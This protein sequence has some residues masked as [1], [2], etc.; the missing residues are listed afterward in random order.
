MYAGLVL[1][2]ADSSVAQPS[3]LMLKSPSLSLPTEQAIRLAQQAIP[4]II[5]DKHFSQDDVFNCDEFMVQPCL[6]QGPGMQIG[7]AA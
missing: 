7:S 4:A 1:Q 5:E 6:V 2:G 3:S